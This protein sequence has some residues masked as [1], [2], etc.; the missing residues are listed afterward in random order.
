[1]VLGL[2][3]INYPALLQCALLAGSPLGA[4][5]PPP[6]PDVGD[7]NDDDNDN[8]DGETLYTHPTL[9]HLM[10]SGCELS[11]QIV[12]SCGYIDFQSRLF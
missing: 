12:S 7:G 1:M 2:E 11:P 6:P 9:I 8:N 5:P 3:L 10:K 4:S